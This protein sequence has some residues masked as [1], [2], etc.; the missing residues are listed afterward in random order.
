MR[1]LTESREDVVGRAVDEEDYE[2]KKRE[3]QKC[4]TRVEQKN[5]RVLSQL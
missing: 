5:A 1:G 4:L 2:R 3:I